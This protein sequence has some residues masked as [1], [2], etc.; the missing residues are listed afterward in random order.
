VLNLRELPEEFKNIIKLRN[1]LEVLK[2]RGGVLTF[3][4]LTKVFEEAGF[5]FSHPRGDDH[6][7]KDP[8][9]EAVVK[10]PKKSHSSRG[11]EFGPNLLA[12]IS[13]RLKAITLRKLNVMARQQSRRRIEKRVK[14]RKKT[15][16]TKGWRRR[17]EY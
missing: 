10:L 16:R 7:Y 14:S 4:E 9:S 2:K 3:R 5:V 11:G 6:Y 15:K 13:S 1:A 17:G 8:L 12:E